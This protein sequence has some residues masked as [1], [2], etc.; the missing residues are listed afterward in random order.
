MILKI[1]HQV[2]IIREFAKGFRLVDVQRS[3]GVKQTPAVTSAVASAVFL[4]GPCSSYN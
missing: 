2:F 3:D 4:N 1:Q